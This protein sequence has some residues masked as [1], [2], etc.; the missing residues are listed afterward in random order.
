MKIKSFIFGNS[1][2]FTLVE[3]LI[4]LGILAVISIISSQILVT[5]VSTSV[6]IQKK[7]EIELQ[8][9]FISQK[10]I[11]IIGDGT[12]A[13][14]SSGGN[15]LEISQGSTKTCFGVDNGVIEMQLIQSTA[16]CPVSSNSSYVPLNNKAKIEITTQGNQAPFLIVSNSNPIQ[17]RIL[18][19]VEDA[20]DSNT[21]QLF[22]RIVTL[23]KT[24]KS[25]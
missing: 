13:S 14:V 21:F 17:V 18:F 1:K 12:L 6:N 3:L 25:L 16:N 24:Y 23:R 20:L 9:S 10:M 5:L 19:K 22:E 15:I 7:N 8:Y 4:S 2:A 11:K